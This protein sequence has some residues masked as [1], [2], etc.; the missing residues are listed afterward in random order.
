MGAY[1]DV[2]PAYANS[3]GAF[4]DV[5]AARPISTNDL[6]YQLITSQ[7]VPLLLIP[8]AVAS[9]FSKQNFTFCDFHFASV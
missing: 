3:D 1:S 7:M 5:Q 2:K 8:E 6:Q 4:P 9:M